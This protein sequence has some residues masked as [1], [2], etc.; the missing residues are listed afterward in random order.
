MSG[1]YRTGQPPTDLAGLIAELD[2]IERRLN[3]LEGPTGEQTYQTVA[4]LS[5]LVTNI[6]AQLDAWVATRWTNS[7]IVT[8]INSS[9][10]SHDA[11][12]PTIGGV[13]LSGGYVFTPNGYNFDITYTRRS[14]WLGNDGRI[15]WASSSQDRKT[16]IRPAN[17][18]VDAVMSLEPKSF[19]YRA[20]IARR[21]ALRINQGVDYTP[22]RE[23][24]LMAQDV[25]AAGL[26]GFVIYD[27]LGNPEG[28]EY[29]MLTVALLAVVRSQR[30]DIAT[31]RTDVDA[32]KAVSG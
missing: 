17:I 8:Q 6:Q 23:L 4:K 12:S 14:A 5:A 30:D 2:E 24:G 15:G 21:T 25:H 19:I 26:K 22:A 10:A 31:L 27:E 1:G 13:S 20:E 29:G 9:L 32:L 7:E 18:D 16:S 11:G 28:I 3:I